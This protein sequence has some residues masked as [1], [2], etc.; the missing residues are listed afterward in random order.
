MTCSSWLSPLGVFDPVIAVFEFVAFV[1]E[2]RHVAAVIDDEFR[3]FVAGERNRLERA[4]PIFFERLAFPGENR[5]A[6]RGNRGGGMVLRRKNVAARPTHIRAEI[7]ERLDQTRRLNRHVQRTRDA[8]ALE[9]FA[10]CAYF[11]GSTSGRAFR[12]RQR[13]FPCGPIRRAKIADVVIFGRWRLRGVFGEGF[14]DFSERALVLPLPF[15][16]TMCCAGRKFN[17]CHNRFL[18]FELF[19]RRFRAATLSVFSQVMLFRSSILPK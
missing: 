12:A 6:G 8:H 16:F 3:A 10:L 11:C 1:D 9:R 14:A 17:F 19:R 5:D 7:H 13:R 4:V 15:S 2:Q 18:F